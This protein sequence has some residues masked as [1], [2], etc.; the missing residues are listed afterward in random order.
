MTFSRAGEE[1]KQLVYV[2]AEVNHLF[3][4]QA[5][6]KDLGILSD[7]FPEGGGR[8]SGCTATEHEDDNGDPCDCPKRTQVPAPPS[9]PFPVG[10]SEQDRARLEQFI[11]DFYKASAFNQC[12]RQPLPL[13][14]GHPPLE[15]HVDED[16]AVSY[17]HLTLPTKRIV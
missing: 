3:L 16:A 7:D 8:V 1:T 14:D 11:L 12:E 9:L 2:A 4:S 5:A 15:L 6:C 13:M 10:E 17:T